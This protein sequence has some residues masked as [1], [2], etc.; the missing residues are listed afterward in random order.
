MQSMLILICADCP[1][2]FVYLSHEKHCFSTYNPASHVTRT[3]ID[4][5]HE[6]LFVPLE[7]YA[8]IPTSRCAAFGEDHQ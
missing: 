4:L 5:R 7:L 1:C 6:D 3:A 2:V 8:S